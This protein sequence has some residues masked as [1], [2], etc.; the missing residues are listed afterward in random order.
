MVN[1]FDQTVLD[2]NYVFVNQGR[3]GQLRKKDGCDT[4]LAFELHLYQ[5]GCLF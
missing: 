4:M 1:C 3:M 2:I 5:F